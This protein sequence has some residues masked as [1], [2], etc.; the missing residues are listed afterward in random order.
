MDDGDFMNVHNNEPELPSL[1]EPLQML[2]EAG[3]VLLLHPD[4]AHAGG[5]NASS[6]IR[7]M[8]YFRVK[9]STKA[10]ISSGGVHGVRVHPK[11][12][13]EEDVEGR[14]RHLP[15]ADD[16]EFLSWAQVEELHRSNMWVDLR[17]LE[18]VEGVEMR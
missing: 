11:H 18:G 5:P 4:T 13:E 15:A 12:A 2:A 1:G 10:N 14:Q 9:C 7:R 16:G 6:E 3:D 17:G 8:V